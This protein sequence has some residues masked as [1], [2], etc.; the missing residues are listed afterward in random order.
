MIFVFPC[1]LFKYKLMSYAILKQFLIA[2][3]REVKEYL[4]W[5]FIINSAFYVSLMTGRKLQDMSSY[6]TASW[7]T[8]KFVSLYLLILK[9]KKDRKLW[10][11]S[12][13]PLF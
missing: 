11:T 1:G 4:K 6:T 10:Q 8:F 9:L 3:E 5:V 7:G 13:F 2:N 12:Y